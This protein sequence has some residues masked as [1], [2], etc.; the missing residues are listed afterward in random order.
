MP[1]TFST[2]LI[3]LGQTN[4]RR[5]EALAN[6]AGRTPQ[7]MISFVL[8]DG[9]PHAH[10]AK[11]WRTQLAEVLGNPLA[12]T[13]FNRCH[14]QNRSHQRFQRHA[15]CEIHSPAIPFSTKLK[16]HASSNLKLPGMPD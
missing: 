3:S 7:A 16:S 15:G 6:Q 14:F 9:R 1:A 5:L 12:P 13:V 4:Y 11:T 2:P 8:R 10:G